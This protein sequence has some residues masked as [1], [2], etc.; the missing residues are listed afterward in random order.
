MNVEYAPTEGTA[1]REQH[2]SARVPGRWLLL[3]RV[4]WVAVAGLALALFIANLPA[5]FALSATVCHTAGC[6]SDQLTP[7]AA[8]HLYAL[9]L[10]LDFFAWY[11][12]VLKCLFVLVFA[13]VGLVI[14]WRRAADRT[15]LVAAFTF[16]IFPITFNLP[17]TFNYVPITLPA[18]WWLPAKIMYVLGSTGMTLLLC[19]FPDGRFVPRWTRWLWLGSQSAFGVL[20]F[21]FPSA[22]PPGGIPLFLLVMS[23]VAV[24]IYR[25]VRVSTP[26]QRQQT[27]WVV[28]GV[29]VGLVGFLITLGL[30]ISFPDL[31]STDTL[32]YV[33][34]SGF[35][36]LSNML[37][38][39]S[40]GLALL[41]YRL[42]D[43]DALINKALVYGLLT[44]LLGALYVGP[45]VG[46]E[47]L[48]GFFG[49]AVV[50]NPVVLVVSTLAIAALFQP[51]RQRI[52]NLIDRRFYRKQY[53]AAKA[54]SAFSATLRQETDLEQIREQVRAVV[55]ETMQPAHVSLWLR[56]PERQRAAMPYHL[57]RH[58]P[59]STQPGDG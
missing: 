28:L 5:S 3:A 18:V 42:W 9:G 46:L 36:F 47:S 48:A 1:S 55:Q 32:L 6:T 25:Y 51:V 16:L 33:I 19:V 35:A 41:R 20:V 8:Q 59:V 34:S 23:L 21:F 4:G 52:Q 54:L 12:L 13:A 38:P 14:F 53:D 17:F 24:Q 44:G 2:S 49:G 57:E 26:V 31:A 29:A 43:V 39:L 10:S 15:A 11:I 50:Q 45:I 22:L 7:A 30:S 27:K 37:I 58:G 56:Q 40:F